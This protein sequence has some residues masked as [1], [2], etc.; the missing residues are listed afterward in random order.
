MAALVQF[1]R[2][3]KMMKGAKNGLIYAP[4]DGSALRFLIHDIVL[5]RCE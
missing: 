4:S 3:V 5:F 1:A 2:Q